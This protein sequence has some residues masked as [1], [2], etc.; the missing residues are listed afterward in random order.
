MADRS[1]VLPGVLVAASAVI[2]VAMYLALG[3][4]G[5]PAKPQTAEV[6]AP[7]ALDGV[8]AAD[9]DSARRSDDH[10]DDSPA[11][12]DPAR[13]PIQLPMVQPVAEAE[14]D[15]RSRPTPPPE[16]GPPV[17]LSEEEQAAQDAFFALRDKVA[18]DVQRQL[19]KQ[20]SALAKACWKPEL[21]GGAKSGTFSLNASFDAS[22]ALIGTGISDTRGGSPGGVGQCLRQQALA[23]KVPASGQAVTVDV[24][25]RLP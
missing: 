1:F 25:L 4:R 16:P 2:V 6:A 18:D 21:T 8:R 5:A 14:L 24:E 17:V 23:F 3:G 11:D 22:G 15:E 13:A 12:D 7:L 20:E 10:P 19:G 9:R